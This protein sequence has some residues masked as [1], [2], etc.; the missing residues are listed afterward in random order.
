MASEPADAFVGKWKVSTTEF[1]WNCIK[2]APEALLCNDKNDQEAELYVNGN[3]VRVQRKVQGRWLS[4]PKPVIGHVEG[5]EILFEKFKM[6]KQGKPTL[7]G[8]S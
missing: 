5:R 2:V 6:I 1:I 8:F 7:V 3:E 4:R